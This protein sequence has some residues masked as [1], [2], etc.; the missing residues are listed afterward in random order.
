[1][2]VAPVIESHLNRLIFAY[3]IKC[4]WVQINAHRTFYTE[5][6]LFPIYSFSQL[7][8]LLWHSHELSLL[9]WGVEAIVFVCRLGLPRVTVALCVSYCEQRARDGR[10]RLETARPVLSLQS[11]RKSPNGSRSCLS[12]YSGSVLSSCWLILVTFTFIR[13]IMFNYSQCTRL[14]TWHLHYI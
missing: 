6:M 9:S 10:K 5:Y 7:C 11:L 4:K 8:I 3:V 1:M 14:H 13:P 12:V 2:T